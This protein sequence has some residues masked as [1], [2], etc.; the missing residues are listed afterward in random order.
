[1][2][3]CSV[4]TLYPDIFEIVYGNTFKCR[5][6]YIFLKSNIFSFDVLK[7]SWHKRSVKPIEVPIIPLWD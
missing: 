6:L 7:E 1:M 2:L 5:N 3:L 4:H